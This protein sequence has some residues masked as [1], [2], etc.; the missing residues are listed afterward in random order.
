M[1][2]MK[3]DYCFATYKLEKPTVLGPKTKNIAIA[4]KQV[5][6]LT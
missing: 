1:L 5:E 3:K 2:R 4:A 6:I